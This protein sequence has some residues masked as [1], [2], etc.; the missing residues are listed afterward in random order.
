MVNKAGKGMYENR[1]KSGDI[2]GGLL[3]ITESC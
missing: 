1:S 2:T 3:R